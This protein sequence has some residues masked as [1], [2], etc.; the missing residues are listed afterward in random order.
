MTTVLAAQFGGFGR[1]LIEL[2]C[3]ALTRSSNV[4]SVEA[5]DNDGATWAPVAG[6]AMTASAA[7]HFRYEFTTSNS[8]RVLL[9][10]GALEGASRSIPWKI[11][12][13]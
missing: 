10:S 13:Y 4:F 5:S 1:V 11:N 6:S 12:V 9:G 2:N 7:Q 3:S 8:F